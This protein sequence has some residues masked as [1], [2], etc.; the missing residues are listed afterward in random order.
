MTISSFNAFYN[1]FMVAY[2]IVYIDLL[3]KIRLSNHGP[4]MDIFWLSKEYVEKFIRF[5]YAR[6]NNDLI[7]CSCVRCYH[8]NRM[9]SN[10][11]KD[12][13]FNHGIDKDFT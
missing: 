2:I 11:I 8:V 1:A 4:K 9:K 13:L 6:N 3:V 10:K 5:A 7:R 12:Y